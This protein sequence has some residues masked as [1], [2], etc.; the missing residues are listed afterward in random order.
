MESIF[1]G[2]SFGCQAEF[3][4]SVICLNISKHKYNWMNGIIFM[5]FVGKIF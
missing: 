4:E 2:D 3:S 5:S 1:V